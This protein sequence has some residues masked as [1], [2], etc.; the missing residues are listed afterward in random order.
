MKE[1]ARFLKD[2]EVHKLTGLGLSTLRN[3]R[4][5]RKGPAYVK[6]GRAVLYE[7]NDVIAWLNSMKI[8]TKDTIRI[9]ND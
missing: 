2:F 8:Q 6:V 1:E 4:H 7:R 5:L 9:K 3:Y